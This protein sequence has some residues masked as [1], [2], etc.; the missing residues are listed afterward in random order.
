MQSCSTC[1]FWEYFY[2]D[3]DKTVVGVCYAPVPVSIIGGSTKDMADTEGQYCL[4]YKAKP[5]PNVDK[6]DAES[7]STIE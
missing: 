2:T 5:G 4:S 3:P 1:V 7:D 6:L